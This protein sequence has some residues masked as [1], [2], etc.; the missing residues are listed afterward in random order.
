MIFTQEQIN[1]IR[2]R[3]AISGTK[4][5]QLP[6]INSIRGN[7]TVT[8]VQ[9][10]ENR[11][12]RVDELLKEC[13]SLKEKEQDAID[14]KQDEE[15]E[16]LNNEIEDIKQKNLYV[17]VPKIGTWDQRPNTENLPSGFQYLL[18]D[19]EEDS[20]PTK[21]TIKPIYW[22]QSAAKVYESLN[23]SEASVFDEIEYREWATTSENIIIGYDNF[24]VGESD[25]PEDGKIIIGDGKAGIG[26]GM[27]VDANGNK[28]D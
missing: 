2:T 1:E 12:M 8:L 3:L 13:A 5:T 22:I 7:E 23:A 28:V 4:D 16:N 10:G 6:L 26:D 24:I 9:Y 19:I 17:G 18:I 14:K 20:D 27:W 15:I 25:N 21:I 11:Q